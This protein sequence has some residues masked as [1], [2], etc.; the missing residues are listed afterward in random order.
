MIGSKDSCCSSTETIVA[1]RRRR[2]FHDVQ[3]GTQKC[4]ASGRAGTAPKGSQNA[5]QRTQTIPVNALRLFDEYSY[6]HVVH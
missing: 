5:R 6:I 3:V 2:R 1:E 4:S